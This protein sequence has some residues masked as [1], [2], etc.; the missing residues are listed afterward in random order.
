MHDQ[1]QMLDQDAAAVISLECNL[2]NTL[3]IH[4]R[5]KKQQV[6]R[7]VCVWQRGSMLRFWSGG[8]IARGGRRLR[9]C[10]LWWWSLSFSSCSCALACVST[11][12]GGRFALLRA[13]KGGDEDEERAR[14]E[15]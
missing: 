10:A 1:V 14:E 7:C 4:D 11:F 5:L 9:E 13:P 3:G 8:T 6:Q 2:R 12:R 15:R